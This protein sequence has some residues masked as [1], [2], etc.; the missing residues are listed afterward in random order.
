M[1]NLKNKLTASMISFLVMGSSCL[2]PV[3]AGSL[4]HRK[5]TTEASAANN[6]GLKKPKPDDNAHSSSRK[7]LPQS[8]VGDDSETIEDPIIAKQLKALRALYSDP[9]SS[10]STN[11]TTSLLD[12]QDIP[13]QLS[14]KKP[15][16]PPRPPRSHLKEKV[17]KPL[18][19]PT[20]ASMGL[21]TPKLNDKKSRIVVEDAPSV[22]EDNPFVV[23]KIPSLEELARKHLKI[24]KALYVFERIGKN[25]PLT[26]SKYFD[27]IKSSFRSVLVKWYPQDH[28]YPKSEGIYERRIDIEYLLGPGYVN[29][30]LRPAK[31]NSRICGTV[32]NAAKL[33]QK[34]E[35]CKSEFIDEIKNSMFRFDCT[36]YPIDSGIREYVNKTY[37]Y[38]DTF[39][40][41]SRELCPSVTSYS[42]VFCMGTPWFVKYIVDDVKQR[43]SGASDKDLLNL[44]ISLQKMFFGTLV[45]RL[46]LQDHP[47][48]IR[49]GREVRYVGEVELDSPAMGVNPEYNRINCRC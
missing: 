15:P 17:S 2:P 41:Y 32:E 5:K 43:F 48:S 28:G 19:S 34:E 49:D 9:I 26:S 13:A 31:I 27:K 14:T 18:R 12:E 45:Y 35:F 4:E 37:I 44:A 38:N 40:R 6:A 11:G 1:K 47:T 7:R 21:S 39:L 16:R 25:D 23:G 20:K 3:F 30:M 24:F 33:K 22:F 10:S 29:Y 36:N 8:V 42:I 46:H